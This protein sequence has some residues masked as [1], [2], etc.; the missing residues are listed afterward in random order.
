VNGRDTRR[1]A[2]G[3]KAGMSRRFWFCAGMTLLSA[4]VSAGFSIVG[5]FS[6][7]ADRYA[8]YAASRSVALLIAA[9]V[10]AALRARAATLALA[11]CMTLVQ[12]FDGWIGLAA[13]DPG[14]TFGPF[15]FAVLNAA[16]A[17]LY[18]RAERARR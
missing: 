13:H 2:R 15:A 3:A 5:L 7:G 18:L 1:K 8:Q 6:D 16:A 4:V 11:G 10:I 14:K 9:L 12:F 17:A